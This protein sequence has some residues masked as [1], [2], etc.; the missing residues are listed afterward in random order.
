MSL[1]EPLTPAEDQLWTAVMRVV[2]QLPSY[3]DADLMRGAGLNASEYT[4][5]MSLCECPHR[6]LRMTDL[7]HTTGLSASRTTRLVDDL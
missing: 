2:I 7:A 5:L 1:P 3:L 6:G 4:T